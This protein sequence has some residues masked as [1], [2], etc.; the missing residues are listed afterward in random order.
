MPTKTG[1]RQ[2]GQ[3]RY[4]AMQHPIR[5]AILMRLIEG[6]E[7]SP[8]ELAQSLKQ[9]IRTVSYHVDR[10]VDL[11]CAELVREELTGSSV[12]HIFRAT[13]RHLVDTEEW[14]DIDP[15]IRDDMLVEVMQT[16]VNDYTASMK[17]KV[18]GK[19]EHFVLTRTPLHGIDQVGLEEMVK[20]HTRLHY[21]ITDVAAR[22][23]E[24][25][26][27][28]GEDG[29]AVSTFQGCIKLPPWSS[30]LLEKSPSVEP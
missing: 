2:A 16:I 10:L 18:L 28:S 21:E 5:R 4:E 6:G 7:S 23:A 14:E 9:S 22:S 12:K 3:K 19:D 25:L 13:D 1:P 30:R 20:I 11:D 29:F 17:G 26:S 27:K 8:S 15:E 24:R